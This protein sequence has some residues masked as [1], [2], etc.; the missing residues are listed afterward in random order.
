[1]SVG[2][3]M[4]TEA[5]TDI[6]LEVGEILP[7]GATAGIEFTLVDTSTWP[8]GFC[9]DGAVT[10][11]T[12][13]LVIWEVRAEVIGEITSIWNAEY[14]VDGAE[15]VFTGVEWNAELAGYGSTTFGFCGTR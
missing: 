3:R 14:T 15:H 9:A 2:S 8:G 6:A 11:T 4:S 12:S 7:G 5:I 1:M 10:N 13:E